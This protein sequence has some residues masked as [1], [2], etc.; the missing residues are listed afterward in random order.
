MLAI[1]YGGAKLH[2]RRSFKSGRDRLPYQDAGVLGVP[3]VAGGRVWNESG[4]VVAVKIATVGK[5]PIHG[6]DYGE[7]DAF[8]ANHFTERRFATE[9]FFAQFGT[10]K[11]HAAALCNVFC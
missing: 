3:Q 6:A 7:G 9:K 8:D 1:D 10:E 2:H 11:D 4:F 5:L